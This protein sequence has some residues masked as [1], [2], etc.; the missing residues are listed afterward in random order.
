MRKLRLKFL[1]IYLFNPSPQKP[2]NAEMRSSTMYT[3]EKWPAKSP[4]KEIDIYPNLHA[5]QPSLHLPSYY[6]K[7]NPR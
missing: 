7:K 3:S 6:N 1:F 2:T 5:V 4:K